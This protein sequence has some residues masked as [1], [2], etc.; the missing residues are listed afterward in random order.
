MRSLS[1]VVAGVVT[2]VMTG[3]LLAAAT[4]VANA[5]YNPAAPPYPPDVNNAASLTVYDAT[6]GAIVTS[7]STA[8]SLS[9]YYFV[10]NSNF[11][12]GKSRATLSAY[13]AENKD[14]GLW[15][16]QS[17]AAATTYPVT[18]APAPVNGFTNPV[19]RGGSTNNFADIS[20]NFPNLTPATSDLFHLYQ[21][22]VNT[23]FPFPASSTYAY[24][25][26]QIDPV[27]GT[28]QQVGPTPPA[29][30]P[31]AP[32]K[33]SATAGNAS[34]SVTV[35]AVTGATSYA[36]TAS[37]GGAVVTGAGP[38]FAFTGLT[39]GTAYTFTATATNSGGTSAA[40]PASDPVTPG[41]PV[42]ASS[43]SLAVSGGPF[44]DT[45]YTFTATV[46]SA[47]APTQVNAGSVSFFDN[48]STTALGTV[49][50]TSGGQ[51]VLANQTLTAGAHS[52]VAKFTPTT[53]TAIAASQSA[54]SAFS[55][56][57]PLTGACTN[58]LSV[59][60][61]TQYVQVNVPVGTLVINTPYTQAS[62]LVLPPMTLNTAG[63]QLS[64]NAPFANIVVTDTRSGDLPWTAQALAS[65]LNNGTAAANGVINAQNVGL[66]GLS[67]LTSAGYLGTVTLSDNAAASPAVGPAAPGSAGLGG[68]A[69]T[70]ASTTIGRGTTTMNGTL[71]INA[72]TSTAPGTYNG[73]I[74]FT[75]G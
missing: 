70:F 16:G 74:I 64:S 62:P 29:A 1:K 10:A 9:Q 52:I 67:K 39:N 75:V 4:G 53:A 24:L 18:T 21:F 59:C 61:D 7:G 32:G 5:A 37:P 45:P 71:T 36:V 11:S 26:V 38:T 54:A 56:Q 42:P 63:T 69:K 34:A 17:E 31:V 23:T 55:T 72:P 14:P 8:T 68:T 20:T 12:P 25:D 35:P 66:T 58:T 3:G 65:N 57:A 49:A 41:A 47:G 50:G 27:A 46:S 30:A 6:T 43:T 22:R 2:L 28:W 44:T 51:Y 48:G 13:L 15:S 60:S 33:P 40:S 73:T 19:A